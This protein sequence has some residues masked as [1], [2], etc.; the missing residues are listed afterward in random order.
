MCNLLLLLDQKNNA[1]HVVMVENNKLPSSPQTFF[2]PP[3]KIY[4]SIA[5]QCGYNVKLVVYAEREHDDDYSC[6]EGSDDFDKVSVIN[7]D[8]NMHPIK[9]EM[10]KPISTSQKIAY[11]V[12]LDS[13][14]KY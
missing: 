10:Y 2:G 11:G 7:V 6:L 13:Y 8:S 4:Q 1:G 12:L 9:R 14:K 3:K 5:D